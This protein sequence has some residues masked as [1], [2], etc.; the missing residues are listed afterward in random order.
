MAYDEHLAA[1][2]REILTRRL[3]VEERKMFGGL[4]FLVRGSMCCG[5]SGDRLMARIGRGAYEEALS[6]E[7]V[8]PMDFTGRPLKGFVYVES[9]GVESDDALQSWID[10]CLSFVLTLPPK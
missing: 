7:H 4:A 5:I 8:Q 1:R 2:A 6:E 9:A 10:R 3:E